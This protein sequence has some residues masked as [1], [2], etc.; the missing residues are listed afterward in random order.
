MGIT[1]HWDNEEQTVLVQRFQGEWVL[2]DYY[3]SLEEIQQLLY[4]HEQRVH[5]I[6]DLSE[7]FTPTSAVLETAPYAMQ[8]LQGCIGVGVV[9]GANTFMSTIVRTVLAMYPSLRQRLYLA[10]DRAS[11]YKIMK[12]F[13]A[14]QRTY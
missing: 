10:D 1:L 2:N 8:R 13:E 5:L 14:R 3:R 9:L 6:I 12:H 11:A 7:S 4:D